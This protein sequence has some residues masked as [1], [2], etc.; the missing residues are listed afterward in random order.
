[1]QTFYQHA[2]V[3][4]SDSTDTVYIY[5]PHPYAVRVRKLA[6]LPKTAVA[7]HASNYITTTISNGGDTLA[8]HTTNS[9]G[10]SALA[11]GTEKSLTISG[12]GTQLE[13]AAGGVLTVAV[14]K[15]G[16][17]PAYNH[18]VGAIFEPLRAS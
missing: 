2:N 11:A 3:S 4:G 10:G 7:T 17:G 16:T 15:A 9:T 6:I 8:T 5:N 13:V 14:T 18:Q 12:T 1:M